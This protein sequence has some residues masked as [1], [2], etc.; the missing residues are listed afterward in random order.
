MSVKRVVPKRYLGTT[1]FIN[2]DFFSLAQYTKIKYLNAIL[3]FLIL[4]SEKNFGTIVILKDS[5][6]DATYPLFTRKEKV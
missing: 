3:N 1:L 2:K 4:H 6:A 5:Y